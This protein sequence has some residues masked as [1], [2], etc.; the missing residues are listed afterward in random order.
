MARSPH[1]FPIWYELMAADPDAAQAFYGEVI[2]WHSA[3]SGQ[4]GMDYRIFTRPQGEAIAGL[5]KRP[6]GAAPARWFVYFG[7]DD[8]DAAVAAAEAEGGQVWMPAMTVPGVGRLALIAD[9]GGNP[10]YVMRG[11]PD[12]SSTAFA[13]SSTGQVPPGHAVWNE[14]TADDQDAALAFYGKLLGLRHEGGMPMG[15]LGEYKFVHAGDTCIGASMNAQPD[16][17]RGWQVY[18]LVDEIDAAARR[19]KDAGGSV[20]QGPD[21]IPGGGYAIVAADDAGVRFGMVGARLG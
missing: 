5:I 4:A 21:A 19:L 15:E 20:V 18:F 13:D 9:P 11:E 7:V 1:G 2:G 10:F 8:V 3:D 17:P 6:D 14:L 16:W 12:E